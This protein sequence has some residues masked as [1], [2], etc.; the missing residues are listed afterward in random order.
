MRWTRHSERRRARG[1]TATTDHWAEAVQSAEIGWGTC[2]QRALR[3]YQLVVV[4][5]ESTFIIYLGTYH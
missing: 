1:S 2:R 5:R 3:M 4:W